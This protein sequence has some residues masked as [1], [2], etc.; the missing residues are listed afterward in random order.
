MENLIRSAIG[1]V[2]SGP[3]CFEILLLILLKVHPAIRPFLFIHLKL[4]VWGLPFGNIFQKRSL[5]IRPNR[6]KWYFPGAQ[7]YDYVKIAPYA[8]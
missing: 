4:K 6:V 7:Y 3:E 1:T 8:E 5:P 2:A